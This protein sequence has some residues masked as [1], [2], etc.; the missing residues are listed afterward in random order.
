MKKRSTNIIYVALG[1]ALFSIGDLSLVSIFMP[2]IGFDVDI[3]F[4]VW[5]FS[6]LFVI[7]A[8]FIVYNESAG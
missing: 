7:M 1:T 4:P 2:E 3:A 5:V 8:I 6:R